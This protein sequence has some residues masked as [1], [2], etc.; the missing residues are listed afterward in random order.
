MIACYFIFPKAKDFS[1]SVSGIL[2]RDWPLKYIERVPA[3]IVLFLDLDWDHFSWLEK[4]T[5]AESKCA[6]LRASAGQAS[7]IAVVLL[8]QRSVHDRNS[9]IS[10]P[11]VYPSLILDFFFCYNEPF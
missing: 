2:R 10:W 7:R 5:E 3:L 6:S 1:L 11:I 4:K 8:Q 9:S